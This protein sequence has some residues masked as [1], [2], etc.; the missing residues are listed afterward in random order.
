MNITRDE[1]LASYR[2]AREAMDKFSSDLYEVS[3]ARYAAYGDTLTAVSNTIDLD[4]PE[5]YEYFSAVV[6]ATR[7]WD[8]IEIYESAVSEAFQHL[9][10]EEDLTE[11]LTHIP[12][13][14]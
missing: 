14:N 13:D 12:F 11:L 1:L 2:A 6:E 7:I 3:S 4:G 10:D 8:G 9:E 5:G